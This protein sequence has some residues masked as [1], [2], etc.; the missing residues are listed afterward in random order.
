MPLF[1]KSATHGIENISD[2]LRDTLQKHLANSEYY[3]IAIDESIDIMEDAQMAVF[4]R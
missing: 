3:S 4:E 1:W 2:N